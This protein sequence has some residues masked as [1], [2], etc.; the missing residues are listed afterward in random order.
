M[1]PTPSLVVKKD[2]LCSALASGG[3]QG[4]IVACHGQ[5]H[6]IVSTISSA[7]YTLLAPALL[8]Q[9]RFLCVRVRG[10]QQALG[11]P[12]DVAAAAQL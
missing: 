6:P 9:R 8:A 1:V 5:A 4:P 2:S 11:L 12:A 7:L 3:P 10:R